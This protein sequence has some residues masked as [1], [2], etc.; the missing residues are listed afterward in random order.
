LGFIGVT[1]PEIIVAEGIQR[2]PE[3]RQTAVEG[4]LQAANNLRAA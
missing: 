2:G 1:A 3:H 4:A